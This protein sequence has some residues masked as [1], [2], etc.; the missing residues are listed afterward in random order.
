MGKIGYVKGFQNIYSLFMGL[1]FI[2]ACIERAKEH[3]IKQCWAKKLII[4]IL[5]KE[6]Y[7]LA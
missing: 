3:V 6:A 7:S 5:K 2:D 1:F 4:G